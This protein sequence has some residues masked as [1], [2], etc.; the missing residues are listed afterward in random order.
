M[1][2]LLNQIL[3]HHPPHRNPRCGDFFHP[4][5]RYFMNFT[6]MCMFPFLP[7]R[8]AYAGRRGKSCGQLVQYIMNCKVNGRKL[9]P[10]KPCPA[11]RGTTHP[12]RTSPAASLVPVFPGQGT[13]FF[14]GFCGWVCGVSPATF[15]LRGSRPGFSCRDLAEYQTPTH[16][17]EQVP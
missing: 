13:F 9:H 10:T 1:P 12:R 8:P 5:C 7:S 11:S 16:T 17:P 6:S 3:L 4:E 2:R 14:H 15:P